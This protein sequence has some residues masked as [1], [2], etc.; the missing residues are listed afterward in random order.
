VTVDTPAGTA[1]KAGSVLSSRRGQILGLGPHP[2]WP[3]WERVDALL[4]ESALDG[5]DAELRSLSQGL[6]T[7]SAEFD[8]LAEL[9]GKQADEVIK[10]RQAEPA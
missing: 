6:A 8:H 3:R 9:G 2:D 7:Y 1:S 5:L 10:A 4:P